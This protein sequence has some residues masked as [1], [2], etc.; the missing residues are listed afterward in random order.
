MQGACLAIAAS[1]EQQTCPI[2]N[3]TDQAASK[4]KRLNPYLDDA[5]GLVGALDADPC[6]P[7]RSSLPLSGI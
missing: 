5:G 6:S 2:P 4:C 1:Y 7:M 3:K